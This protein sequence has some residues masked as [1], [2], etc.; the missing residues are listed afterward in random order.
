[1]VSSTGELA[2]AVGRET[3]W[4]STGTLA[5]VPLEGGAPRELLEN[6]SLAD[7]SPD[8]RELAVVRKVGG[9]DRVEFPIGKVLYESA[10][11]IFSL[12]FSPR[13]DRLAVSLSEPTPSIVVVDLSGKATTVSK[14]WPG[15]GN[16]VAVGGV[17]WRPDGS[18]IWFAGQRPSEKGAIYAVTPSGRLRMVRREAGGLY[19]HD[20]SRDGRALL[21]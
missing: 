12:R 21:N 8:G 13:G 3:T 5:R 6:V 10:E 1:A 17:A 7:W 15:A 14:G 11:A 2:I 16:W 4:S 19:L 18:E 9:K 20:L